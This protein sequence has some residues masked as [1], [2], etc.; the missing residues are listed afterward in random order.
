MTETQAREGVA[1]WAA[2]AEAVAKCI[3]ESPVSQSPLARSLL[4][5]LRRAR[6]CPVELPNFDGGRFLTAG[7]PSAAGRARGRRGKPK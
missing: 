1:F 5:E 6:G 7:R 2:P 3:E 4:K